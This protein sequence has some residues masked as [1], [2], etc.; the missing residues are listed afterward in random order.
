MK[1]N[2]KT[3]SERILDILDNWGVVVANDPWTKSKII[4]HNSKDHYF[5]FEVETQEMVDLFK[6]NIK[7]KNQEWWVD[8]AYLT[9][10]ERFLI[11]ATI[12]SVTK[13]NLSTLSH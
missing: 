11:K 2:T 7:D 3:F 1:Q 13:E 8:S 4:S 6:K 10:S 5:A 9:S 12:T